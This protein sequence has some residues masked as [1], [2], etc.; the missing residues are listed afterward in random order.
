MA[1]I[2]KSEYGIVAVNNDVIA[3]L[4]AEDMMSF[5]G[6][7]MPCNSKGKA[8]KKNFLR[9]YGN[10]TDAVEISEYNTDVFVRVYFIIKFGESIHDVSYELFKMIEDDF[11]L[12]CLDKPCELKASIKGV[13]SE[14][15]AKTNLEV[16]KRN[17]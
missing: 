1:L 14:T 2:T 10:M 9:G 6:V 8:L 5:D 17:D 3:K 12:L 4:I 11:E 13:K 16:T 15:V 7:I